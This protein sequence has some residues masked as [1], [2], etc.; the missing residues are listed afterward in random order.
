MATTYT[1]CVIPKPRVDKYAK[2]DPL[3]HRDCNLVNIGLIL[4]ND[5]SDRVSFDGMQVTFNGA[6]V[7][8]K[9]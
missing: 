1:R 6:I 5:T 3:N 2:F 4:E 7:I 8:F 9:G